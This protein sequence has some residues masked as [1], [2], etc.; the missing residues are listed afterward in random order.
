[1]GE[2]MSRGEESRFSFRLMTADDVGRVPIGCQGDEAALR[3]RIADVGSAAVLAFDGAQHVAQLQFRRYDQTCR[4]PNGLW[5]PLY[6]GEFGDTA[7]ALPTN[8]LSIFCYH[9]GQ[10]DDSERRDARYQGR[11]LG[12][13]LLDYLL[14]WAA[15]AG[16]AAI[17]AKATPPQRAVMG[18]M[19]G[20]PTDI[21]EARGFEVSA[22]WIDRQL[23][24]VVHEKALLPEGTAPDVAARVSL[25]VKFLA[26][27]AE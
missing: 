19:G 21:Y 11:G 9:V 17:A 8:S 16:F 12:V 27:G 2:R 24:D 1:M 10:L 5:D 6:W 4:S 26:S 14:E 15:G 22:S 18:F 23:L 25:C 20:Q 3:S 13:A 7:P